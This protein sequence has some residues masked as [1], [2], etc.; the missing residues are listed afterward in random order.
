M[1]KKKFMVMEDKNLYLFSLFNRE[2]SHF[3]REYPAL[4][5]LHNDSRV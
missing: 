2:Q 3:L 4:L 1:I 5:P